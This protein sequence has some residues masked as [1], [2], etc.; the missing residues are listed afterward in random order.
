MKNFFQENSKTKC[1]Q[2]QFVYIL[3][4]NFPDFSGDAT[5][6]FLHIKTFISET[7]PDKILFIKKYLGEK[8]LCEYFFLETSL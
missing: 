5:T 3:F 1:K 7:S 6:F 4:A 2:T 8:F